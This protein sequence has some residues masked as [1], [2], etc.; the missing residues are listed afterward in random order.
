[1]TTV[2]VTH[3]KNLLCQVVC[4]ALEFLG[5][6]AW[7]SKLLSKTEAIPDCE[8]ESF[9]FSNEKGILSITATWRKNNSGGIQK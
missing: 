3:P 1:M 6:N 7:G 8:L 4:K 5:I 9:L 2:T